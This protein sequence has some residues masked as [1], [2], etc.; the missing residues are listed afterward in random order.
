M[1][2][3]IHSKD[4]LP[5][6]N[7]VIPLQNNDM[8]YMSSDGYY[9]QFGGA[10]NKKFL[11]TNFEKMLLGIYNLDIKEQKQILIDRYIDWKGNNEQ[12]DD[13][14]VMGIRYKK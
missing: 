11:M 14:H 2:I 5:F 8:I 12:V 4:T 1:P 7:N 10:R 6:T 13:V 3:G 9:D